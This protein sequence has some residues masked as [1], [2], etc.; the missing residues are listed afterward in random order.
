MTPRHSHQLVILLLTVSITL[1]VT[2]L[3][4]LFHLS[5]FLYHSLHLA[6]MA[7]LI[8]SQLALYLKADKR[9]PGARYALWFAIGA[10]FTL[11]GDYVNGA[12]SSV[13]PVSLKLTWA[14]LLFGLGYS[15]YILALWR[16]QTGQPTFAR[17]IGRGGYLLALLI[18]AINVISWFHHVEVNLRGHDLLYYGSFVFNA[19][20]YV[21]MPLLA[22]HFYRHSGYS[23]GGLFVLMGGLLIPYSDL[24][25]FASWLR[26]G[27][28]VVPGFTLYAFNWI[29]YFGGQVLFSRFPAL[30]LE[31]EAG[32][33]R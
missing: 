22:F 33:S 29:A 10:A 17:T 4:G 30:V 3:A 11:I 2:L 25:L 12:V 20:I 14:M 32:S 6:F 21:L 24:V 9:L 26:G 18:L 8:G 5:D 23:T 28:P 16:Y 13:Q 27:D 7:T 31:A 15:L 19:T 1:E